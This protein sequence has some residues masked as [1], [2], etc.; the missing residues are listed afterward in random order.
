MLNASERSDQQISK[1]LGEKFNS[2]SFSERDRRF[3]TELISGTIRLKGRL[4]WQLALVYKGQYRKLQV[5]IRNLL[6]LGA[7]QLDNMDS[8]PE[9]AAVSTV[10]NL[11]K[12]V[13]PGAG[14][15]VNGVLRNY[16]RQ[17]FSMPGSS[18]TLQE[19]AAW[20][21]HPEWLIRRWI[22]QFGEETAWQIALWNNSTPAVWFRVN[23]VKTDAEAFADYLSTEQ[24]DY[25]QYE[26]DLNYFKVPS[27]GSIINSEWMNGGLV[28]VQDPAAAMIIKLLDPQMDE[29]I[30]DGCSAPGGKTTY[31]AALVGEKG[32]VYAYD[33]DPDRLKLVEESS[34]RLGLQNIRSRVAD[35]TIDSLELADKMLLDVPCSGTGV[36]A[37][38]ADLRWRRHPES[39]KEFARL[40]FAILENSA[41]YLNPGGTLV[42]STCTLEE[43]ENWGVVERFLQKHE[44]YKLVSAGQFVEESFVDKKGALFT[45]PPVHKIDGGFAVRI[46]RV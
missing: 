13:N 10:V 32:Q 19:K 21:S 33:Q 6:R 42:Y 1:I 15:L 12:K 17:D 44:E 40:Q 29:Q 41:R 11:A 25:F 35:L 30:I 45:L 2:S 4:D 16:I 27:A 34:H 3:L 8:V 5:E 28:S 23:S 37:R 7:Y 39:I 22:K 14:K 31:L 43:E 38:R 36:M 9:Y 20:Y 18:S 46:T 24:I 26:Q